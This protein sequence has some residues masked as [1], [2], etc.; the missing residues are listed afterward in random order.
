MDFLLDNSQSARVKWP[1]RNSGRAGK[2]VYLS[3]LI[4]ERTQPS[5]LSVQTGGGAEVS[6]RL[7]S[8]SQM[9]AQQDH[10]REF[11]GYRINR[12]SDSIFTAP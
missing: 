8:T 7:G 6:L 10:R 11:K 1:G 5:R 9:D 4:P 12:E 2:S 3:K